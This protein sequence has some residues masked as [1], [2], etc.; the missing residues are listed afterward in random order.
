VLV[1]DDNVDLVH[2]YRRY[3]AGTRYHIVHLSQGTGVLEA[4]ESVTP[5]IIVLDVMLPD[6]DGWDLLVQLHEHPATRPIPVVVCSVVREEE[7]ALSLGASVYLP[8]P[9]RRREFIGAL[10]QAVNLTL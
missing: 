9:V 1:V 5:D 8:K 2:F 3:A 7:L 10:D 6:V 4:V